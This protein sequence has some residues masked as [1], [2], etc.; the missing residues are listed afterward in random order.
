[1]RWN[2]RTPPSAESLSQIIC[3]IDLAYRAYGSITLSSTTRVVVGDSDNI[4]AYVG[5]H[6]VDLVESCADMR[7]HCFLISA[8]SISYVDPTNRQDRASILKKIPGRCG[9]CHH[10][11]SPT[12]T[13]RLANVPGQE[14]HGRDA[15][16]VHF[17]ISTGLTVPRV[18]IFLSQQKRTTA[19][20]R[21]QKNF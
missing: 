1:L 5:E 2:A 12:G 17:G 14:P 4:S 20:R 18:W 9:R 3:G 6:H 8:S 13:K 19:T 16:D 21:K 10:H 15:P 11:P 7:Q